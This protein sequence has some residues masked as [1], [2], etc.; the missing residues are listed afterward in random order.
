MWSRRTLAAVT[1]L[2]VAAAL[3]G[4][5]GTNISGQVKAKVRQFARAAAARDYAT[6]CRQVLA[7]ALLADLRRGGIGC[8]RAMSIALSRVRQPRLAVGNVKVDGKHASALAISQAANQ[9]TVLTSI[10]LV[11]TARGWRIS[12]LGS[13]VG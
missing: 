1:A 3:G 4:C 7:P 8:E 9:K 10:Q 12:S 5:G 2:G 11:D 6:I 13:P